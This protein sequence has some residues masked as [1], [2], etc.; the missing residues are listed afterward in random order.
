MATPAELRSAIHSL[1][2]L[3]AA[4]L[5]SVW[6]KVNTADQAQEALLNVLP[7]LTLSYR[8]A[9]ASVAA[10][11]YDDLRD[12]HRIR[13][14]FTALVPDIDDGGADILARWG[15]G[16]LYSAQPDWS[17]AKALVSGGLQ[18]RIANAAR[19]TVRESAIEDPEAR[20][21]QRE[22]SGGCEFCEML[23]GRGIVYDEAS[24]DFA[25]HTNCNCIAVPAFEG[26][27][28]PVKAYTPSPRNITDADRTRVREYISQHRNTG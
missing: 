11:W 6:S 13:R 25:S 10:D 24:A 18:L 23:A 3:A 17:R 20:G 8:L 19:D 15:V 1:S 26:R 4:D 7:D 16:P 21:W 28:K 14:K 5:R 12:H 9:S 22:T 27:E 2:T